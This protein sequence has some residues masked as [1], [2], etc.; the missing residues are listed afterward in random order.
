MKDLLITHRSKFVALLL[1]LTPLLLLATSAGASAG[2]ASRATP[3]W[4]FSLLSGAQLAMI[5][6]TGRFASLFGEGELLKDV[7]RL[8]AENAVL[9]EEKARLIGVLQEN[10]RLRRLV[11]FKQSHPEYQLLPARVI[12]RDTSPYFRVF[13]IRLARSEGD[14]LAPRQPVV[15]AGGVVGQIHEVHDDYAQV[16]LLSDPR[17][18]ID[19]ISQRNR[20]HGIAFGLG[21]ERDYTASISYLSEKDSV[22]EGDVMV[23]SGLGGTFPPELIVGEVIAVSPDERGL[24]QQVVISPA[25]DLSRVEEVF[26]I[27]G[28]QTPELSA[29]PAQ[30]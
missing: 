9:R 27:T 8:E 21:H 24:F 25:V 12:A 29:A 17:S 13:S 30:E 26:V 16:V 4:S 22:R 14:N 5:D 2:D 11:G 18:R 6:L 28:S 15:V 1:C 23:T 7:A 19:V 3:S 20:A 10:E